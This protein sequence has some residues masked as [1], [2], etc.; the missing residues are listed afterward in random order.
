MVRL[1]CIDA[2]VSGSNPLSAK[3][4]VRMRRAASFVIPGVEVPS[5]GRIERNYLDFT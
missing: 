3:L 4:S 5:R 1:L 2:L